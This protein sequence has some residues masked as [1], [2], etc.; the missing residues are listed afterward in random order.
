MVGAAGTLAS[1]LILSCSSGRAP[2]RGRL[3][4]ARVVQQFPAV[5]AMDGRGARV[6]RVFPTRHMDHLDPFV[7][8]DDFHVSA[9][10]GFP[11]HPH[12]GFEAFTYMIDGAFHH[13]DNLGNDSIIHSGGTQRFTSGAGARHS[14]MPVGSGVNRGLQLWVNLPRR[15][16][17]MEP[18]YLGLGGDKLPIR[19]DVG[20]AVRTIVGEGSEVQLRTRVHYLDVVFEQGAEF[21]QW[22]E[23]G[24]TTLLYVMSGQVMVGDR[25]LAYRDAARISPGLLTVIGDVHSRVAFLS[26]KPH[27]EPIYHHGP[28]VD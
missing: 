9:P 21:T 2:S 19:D 1:P 22:V 15:L 23:Q 13:K 28:Y 6:H 26:G 5:A 4:K 14:E 10:G 27:N 12:R 20:F 17:K 8:L 24:M 3:S 11:E 25:L 16:K 18:E 7:L